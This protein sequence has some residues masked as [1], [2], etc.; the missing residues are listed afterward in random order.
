[1]GGPCPELV[2]S[3]GR[4][5]GVEELYNGYGRK[6]HSLVSEKNSITQSFK[7][8]FKMV[9]SD[10]RGPR[11]VQGACRAFALSLA[12]ACSCLLCDSS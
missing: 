2:Q 12:S 4:L 6:A 9:P 3:V 8:F 11:G 10:W 1:M 5:A 7:E